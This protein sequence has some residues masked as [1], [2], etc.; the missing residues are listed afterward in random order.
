MKNVH[1]ITLALHRLP[2]SGDNSSIIFQ[3]TDEF[4]DNLQ[5]YIINSLNLEIFVFI[6]ATKVLVRPRWKD[7]VTALELQHINIYTQ[8]WL[9]PKS[10]LTE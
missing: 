5:E 1:I 4:I 8:A 6:L 2:T 7:C 9:H 3:S 10:C